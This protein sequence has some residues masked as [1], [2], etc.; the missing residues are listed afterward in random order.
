MSGSTAFFYTRMSGGVAHA[1]S[2]RPFIS[3]RG[4]WGSQVL[5]LVSVTTQSRND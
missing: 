1:N 5:P 4:V 2:T 3:I